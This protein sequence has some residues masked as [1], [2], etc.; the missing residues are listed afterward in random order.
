MREKA[1][2]KPGTFN[3]VVGCELAMA[4]NQLV[5]QGHLVDAISLKFL[6]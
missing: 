4:N 1:Q 3:P 2:F 6:A 5:W